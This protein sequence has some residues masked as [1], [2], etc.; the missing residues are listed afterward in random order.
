MLAVF[1]LSLQKHKQACTWIYFKAQN[2]SH[3][4]KGSNNPSPTKQHIK[5]YNREEEE[6]EEEEEGDTNSFCAGRGEGK[7]QGTNKRKSKRKER[8]RNQSRRYF[9]TSTGQGTSPVMFLIRPP[10]DESA[11]NTTTSSSPL[12]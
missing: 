4:F 5:T 7:I 12:L 3:F 6:E 2:R 11:S 8:R 9:H 10:K 1:F